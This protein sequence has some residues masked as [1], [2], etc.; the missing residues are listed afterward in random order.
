MS[1]CSHEILTLLPPASPRLQCRHC[2]LTIT[3]SELG[4][5]YCPECL[6]VNKVRRRDF[7]TVDAAAGTAARYRCERC[8][9]I[10]KSG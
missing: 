8:G 7:D 4:D 5:N 9:I 10:V 2:H 6:E 1:T 3:E